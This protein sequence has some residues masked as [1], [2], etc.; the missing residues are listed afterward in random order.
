[1]AQCPE[2][3]TVQSDAGS[4]IVQ[5]TLD[6]GHPYPAQPHTYTALVAY[7]DT[8]CPSFVQVTVGST[9]R[10]IGSNVTF[11]I[12]CGKKYLHSGGHQYTVAW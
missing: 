3:V 4:T 2:T 12:G 11:T 9:F 7:T 8:P 5:C 1:M 10:T 6:V